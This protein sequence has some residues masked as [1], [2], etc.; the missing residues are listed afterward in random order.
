MGEIDIQSGQ[1]VT[2]MGWPKLQWIGMSQCDKMST[3]WGGWNVTVENC[4]RV[5]MSQ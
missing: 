5:G 2:A 3:F 1:N 4:H